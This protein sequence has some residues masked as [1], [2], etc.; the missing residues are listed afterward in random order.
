MTGMGTMCR[1]RFGAED[2]IG[3]LWE[4]VAEW[5]EA[6]RAWQTE[7]GQNPTPR[8]GVTLGPWPAGY[9]DDQ[10]WNLDG[11]ANDGVWQQGLPAAMLRGGNWLAGPSAG[12]FALGVSNGPSYANTTLGARCCAGGP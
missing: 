9:Q 3:N 2:M 5:H 10:T 4:W 1:S 12:A 7:D 11:A 6:G 8:S